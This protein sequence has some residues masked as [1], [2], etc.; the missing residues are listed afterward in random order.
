MINSLDYAVQCDASDP[1]KAYR[2]HYIFPQHQGKDAVYF[3]GNSLGLPLKTTAESLGDVVAQWGSF[4]VEGF[5]EGERPWWHLNEE[6]SKALMPV[7]G[8]KASE[9]VC[10]NALTVNLHLLFV[11]FYRPTAARY[12]IVCEEKAFPSDQYLIK[13]QLAWHGYDPNSALLEVSK[14]KEHWDTAVFID[15]IE[16]HASSIAMV[17]LGGV[18]YYNGQHLDIPAITAAAHK[19]NIVVGWDLAHAVGNVPLSLHDWGVDFAAW[20]SYKYLNGGPGAVGGAFVH[21]KHH[22]SNLSRLAGWWGHDKKSRFEMPDTFLPEQGAAGWE[23]STPSILSLTPLLSALKQREA[24]G[25]ERLFEKQE[26][27]TAYLEFVIEN[28]LEETPAHIEIITPKARGSQ[29][30]L[31]LHKNGQHLFKSLQDQGIMVDWREPDAM[32]MA[33]VP[34]YNSF[35]D[36][37]RF[38]HALKKALLLC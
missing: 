28:I 14:K 22:N 23:I 8:G 16:T 25:P 9:I 15:T 31:L 10:M 19:H 2:N 1:L 3:L 13:S 35:Q 7:V 36:V 17:F 6:L 18:N 20:C 4:G 30:T 12:K 34:L 21:Q 5:F 24:I 11:S 38:G 37:Y 33:P 27:L 32:R 26:K 29:L